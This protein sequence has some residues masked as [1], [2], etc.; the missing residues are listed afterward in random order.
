MAA[1]DGGGGGSNAGPVVRA[2]RCNS[3]A[4]ADAAAVKA[5]TKGFTTST[6]KPEYRHTLPG[7][8]QIDDVPAV[9]FDASG[10]FLLVVQEKVVIIFDVATM[11]EVG[12]CVGHTAT[13][14]M[15]EWSRE[16]EYHVASAKQRTKP[17]IVSASEDKTAI[18]WCGVTFAQLAVLRHQG[19][20][21]EVAKARWS[22]NSSMIATVCDDNIVTVWDS[23]IPAPP[24]DDSSA[25]SSD[26]SSDAGS[27]ERGDGGAGKDE[28]ESADAARVAKYTQ[29]K[30][31]NDDDER[32]RVKNISFSACSGLLMLQTAETG[33]HVLVFDA[34]SGS[35]ESV[36][37]NGGASLN[38]TASAWNPAKSST[39]EKGDLALVLSVLHSGG[40][41]SYEVAMYEQQKSLLPRS[42]TPAIVHVCS[43][44]LRHC[45]GGGENK[46]TT[47]LRWSGRRLICADTRGVTLMAVTDH[48]TVTELATLRMDNADIGNKDTFISSVAWHESCVVTGS[49]SGHALL[50]ALAPANSGAAEALLRGDPALG[51]GY[52]EILSPTLF[53]G[54]GP[55]AE[56]L[57]SLHLELC[58]G[59]RCGEGGRGGRSALHSLAHGHDQSWRSEERYFAVL[60][61]WTQSS[62]PYVPLLDDHGLTPL[63]VAV[64]SS[65]FLF[66]EAVFRTKLIVSVDDENEVARA[67]ITE[68]RPFTRG[69]LLP[70]EIVALLETGTFTA[71]AIEY[72]QSEGGEHLLLPAPPSATKGL[73]AL[74]YDFDEA[75]AF[76]VHGE[77]GGIAS[78]SG[79]WHTF[80]ARVSGGCCC[81]GGDTQR[82]QADAYIVG[83]PGIANS[84]EGRRLLHKLVAGE[85][86]T[87]DAF[88]SSA[89]R[90]VVS[91]KWRVYGKMGYSI[92]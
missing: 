18:V 62:A 37:I 28:Q 92:R 59:W 42:E 57:G 12:R 9:D 52:V 16:R 20:D 29:C 30:V 44:P 31:F 15:A 73:P 54:G 77:E 36:A 39:E 14:N 91:Y 74:T 43:T 60:E 85:T 19:E 49:D 76:E 4:E 32:L 23:D 58:N 34:S 71:R 40:K 80:G 68:Q 89:V 51:I 5:S 70:R 7:G 47:S 69:M 56:R 46:V 87:L 38:V 35:W 64:E 24:D 53:D 86:S 33:K 3:A 55:S 1:S 22:P 10:R 88:D 61:L 79:L 2:L 78:A 66:V 65:N 45:N 13:V 72:L 63:E 48:G 90:S 26:D 41:K 27:D 11:V 84:G 75:R 25:D 67:M 17:R 82:T 8:A 21:A 83:V 50:W 6:P 81:C